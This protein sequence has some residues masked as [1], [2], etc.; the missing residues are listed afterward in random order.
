MVLSSLWMCSLVIVRMFFEILQILYQPFCKPILTFNIT[1]NENKNQTFHLRTKIF[2]LFFTSIFRRENKKTNN[3]FSLEI[4]NKNWQN[5]NLQWLFFHRLYCAMQL[6]FFCI[7]TNFILRRKSKKKKCLNC[8]FERRRQWWWIGW[9]KK[10]LYCC[11][12]CRRLFALL[13]SQKYQHYCENSMEI[14]NWNK[15]TIFIHM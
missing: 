4:Q 5:K 9:K 7:S 13:C 8:M 15:S 12:R 14:S 2:Q 6:G 1:H 3:L 11:C 10:K